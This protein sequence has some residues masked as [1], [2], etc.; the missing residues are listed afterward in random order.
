MKMSL[1]HDMPFAMW[2]P[3]S[4]FCI[5]L[6]PILIIEGDYYVGTPTGELKVGCL[7]LGFFQDL[8]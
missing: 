4:F 5:P 3:Y 7:N 8:D 6:I 1:E 2:V